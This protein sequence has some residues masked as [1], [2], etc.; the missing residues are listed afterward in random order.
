MG[1]GKRLIRRVGCGCLGV[2]S[3]VLVVFLFTPLGHT[4][5]TLWKRGYLDSYVSPDSERKYQAG[6]TENLKALYT[7]MNLYH[8]SEGQY[9]HAN[10]WMDAIKSRTST[11]DL[12]KGEADRKFIS[13]SLADK[14]GQ[15]GYAMNDDASAKYKGDLKNPKE[16][17]LF[18]SSDT[19]RNAHGDPKKLLPNPPRPGGNIGIAIDGS[20][21]KL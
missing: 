18:V 20:I 12:A 11:S 3:L 13:P 16:P 4:I 21:V 8:E 1:L 5:R 17:L 15:F 14:P 6:E 2:L 19:S 9:P 10:G 7:A